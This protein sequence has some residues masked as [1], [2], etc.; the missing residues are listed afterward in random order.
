[1]RQEDECHEEEAGD[2]HKDAN[3]HILPFTGRVTSHPQLAAA[4]VVDL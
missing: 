3:D 1:M 2:E 4:E